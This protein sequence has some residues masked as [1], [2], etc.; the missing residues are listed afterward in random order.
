[1]SSTSKGPL[2]LIVD[3]AAPVALYYGLRAAGTSVLV[4]L[5]VGSVPALINAVVSI[6]RER[7]ADL[8]GTAVVLGLLGSAVVALVGGDPRALLVRGAWV[9]LPFALV[10]LWSLRHPQPLC[11][12]VTRAMLPRRAAAMDAL[13]ESNPAWRLAW[14][15]IT[16]MWGVISIVDA[17]VRVVTAYTLPLDV[18]PAVDPFLTVASVIVLQIP[19]HIL[20]RRSGSW[21]LVFSPRGPVVGAGR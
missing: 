3:I 7:R 15:R 17:V 5:L 14:R 9:S 2:L 16:V 12:T 11:Y 10:V 6:A 13:W 20:L 18:V 21:H 8:L 1:M 19:T 4:A